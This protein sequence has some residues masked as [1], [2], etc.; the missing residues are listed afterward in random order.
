M[1]ETKTR[2]A[3]VDTLRAL[4]V[5][6]IIGFWHLLEY[7]PPM[8]WRFHPIF[9]RLTVVVLSLFVLISGYLAGRPKA[10]FTQVEVRRFYSARLLRI[11]PPYLLALLC[12]YLIGGVSG[13]IAAKGALL[14]S[15]VAPPPP[16]TLWFITMLMM[17]YLWAPLLI[18]A[19]ERRFWTTG[20]CCRPVWTTLLLQLRDRG[21][22]AFLS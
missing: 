20:R 14:I 19:N 2:N 9:D 4:S 3:A 17:F 8:A 5:L 1:A 22:A 15:M 18:V 13:I 7:A 11:Y 10:P 21:R 16:Q 12:F 6:Y